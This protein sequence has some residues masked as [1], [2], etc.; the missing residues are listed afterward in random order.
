MEPTESP[1]LSGGEPGEA[2]NMT[3]SSNFLIISKHH[4]ILACFMFCKV[5]I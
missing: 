4:I 1:V 2:I 5:H 3:L